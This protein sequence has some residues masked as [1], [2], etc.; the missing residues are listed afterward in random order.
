[1]ETS[2][3]AVGRRIHTLRKRLNLNQREFGAQIGVVNTVVSAYEVGDAYPS[4]EALCK[5]AVLGNTT[6]DWIT[7]GFDA[8]PDREGLSDH[9]TQ[10]I[11]LYRLANSEGRDAILCVA[12]LAASY[13]K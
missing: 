5:M 2:K 10:L 4:I 8:L 7:T 13:R 9:E 6:I 1:M 11:Q 12:K 3:K